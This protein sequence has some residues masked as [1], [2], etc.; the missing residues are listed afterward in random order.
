M[1]HISHWLLL[2][3]ATLGLLTPWTLVHAAV[4]INEVAWMGTAGNQYEEWL[5]LYNNGSSDVPLAGWK[6]LKD[7]GATTLFNLT[8]TI[9]ANGYLLVCR[10]TTTLTNPLSGTC[11]EQGAFGGSGLGNSGEH[12]QLVDNNKTTIDD[13]PFA[14]GWPAGDASSKQT[15]QKTSSGWG[16]GVGTPGVQ[17]S[18]SDT[19]HLGSGT[20]SD[21][22]A[23]AATPSSPNNQSDSDTT[24]TTSTT[25]PDTAGTIASQTFVKPDPKYTA[26]PLI[27]DHGTAGVSVPMSVIIHQ[28]GHRDMVTGR[29]EWSMGDGVLYSFDQNIPVNHIFYYPGTYTVVLT[30]YSTPFKPEPDAVYQKTITI[31]PPH[32]AITGTTD[33]GGVIF[34]NTSN[35]TIDLEG[36]ILVNSRGYFAFPKYTTIPNGG[37]LYVS[38]H[39][40]GFSLAHNETT[41]KNSEG[42]IIDSFNPDALQLDSTTPHQIKNPIG[43]LVGNNQKKK[44]SRKKSNNS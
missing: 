37:S 24:I 30:Y 19:S 5:E 10:T 34:T 13:L 40:L 29:F 27:P 20:S 14:S 15:M 11:N 9:S 22:T 1:K 43:S 17:N 3:G 2:S 12:L 41:L 25:T 31:I 16:T 38:S 42:V 33:D 18:T 36:W 28:N 23:S 6:I 26:K 8:K 4:S 35:G 32:V 39:T 7:D 21:T 44:K